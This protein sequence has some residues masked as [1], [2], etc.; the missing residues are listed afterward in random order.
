M[1]ITTAGVIGKSFFSTSDYIGLGSLRLSGS[2]SRH[3]LFRL[4]SGGLFLF[5]EDGGA[6]HIFGFGLTLPTTR[7][8]RRESETVCPRQTPLQ[9]K[10][11]T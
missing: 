4:A 10:H 7:R 9:P 1:D 8:R 5:V 6:F 11:A 3:L 2:G